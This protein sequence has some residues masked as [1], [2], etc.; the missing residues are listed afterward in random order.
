[1]PSSDDCH[2][3]FFNG[4]GVSKRRKARRLSTPAKMR[5]QRDA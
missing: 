1:M 4:L 5:H 3:C 2:F